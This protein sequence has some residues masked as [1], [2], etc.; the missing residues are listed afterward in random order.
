MFLGRYA[1]ITFLTFRRPLPPR[2]S[3]VVIMIGR[4]LTYSAML[5]DRDY[6]VT[7]HIIAHIDS[8]CAGG[9][10]EGV[11][12]GDGRRRVRGVLWI[13]SAKSARLGETSIVV[14]SVTRSVQW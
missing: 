2:G 3:G 9:I 4:T 14:P 10:G 12:G 13:W 11:G 7:P 5:K 8:K 1:F 6:D